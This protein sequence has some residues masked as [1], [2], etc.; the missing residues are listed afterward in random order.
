[1]SPIKTILVD[2]EME[3][4]DSLDILLSEYPTIQ[5]LHKISDPID[6]FPVL[7]SSTIDLIFLDIKMPVLSGIDLLVKIRKCNSHVVVVIVTAFDN[8]SMEA[9]KL[10]VFSYM[11]KPIVRV[12]LEQTI[13][14]LIKFFKTER[15]DGKQKIVINSKSTTLL[16]PIADIVYCEAEGSYTFIYLK[17]G[18][19]IVA[20][21]SIGHV[22]QKLCSELF[23]RL[24][25]SLVVN[26]DFITSVNKKEKTCVLKYDKN[27]IKLP[28][29]QLFIRDFNLLFTHV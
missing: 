20:T 21:S 2:D 19:K 11:L 4:L 10:H 15:K 16:V 27:E 1:M 17:D 26:S 12:E 6:V 9:V 3:A 8:Y 25:R 28:V 13:N 22:K 24:N 7:M 18:T 29:T 5:V 23:I 14:E